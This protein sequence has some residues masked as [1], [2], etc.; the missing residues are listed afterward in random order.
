MTALPI[1]ETQAGD[2]SAYIPTNVISITDGQI[3]LESNLFFAGQ[4]PAVNVGLSV[5]RVGGDAQTKAMKQSAGSLRI[6]LAQ[7]REMEAF[8]Q[9][10]SDLDEATKKQLA[11]G[12]SLMRLLR[13]AQ[14][15]PYSQHRMVILLIAALNHTME[16]VP[17]DE[18][19]TYRDQMLAAVERQCDD[20]C[21]HIDRNGALT[22]HDRNLL[23]EAVRDFAKQWQAES[24]SESDE[25]SDNGER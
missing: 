13:Q 5:S 9:F 17:L 2:V 23:L 14:Y 1:I 16:D 15:Q 20:V 18:L 3:Y 25:E 4:R 19:L 6:D 8:T 11:Y 21:R 22:E 12:Q 10:S 24:E 7:F